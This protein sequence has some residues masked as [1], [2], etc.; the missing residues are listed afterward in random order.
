MPLQ[1]HCPSSAAASSSNAR[2]CHRSPHIR[3]RER[4]SVLCLCLIEPCARSSRKLSP[5]VACA[6][7]WLLLSYLCLCLRLSLHRCSWDLLL[8]LLLLVLVLLL[9]LRHAPSSCLS[10]ALCDPCCES[11]PSPPPPPPSPSPSPTHRTPRSVHSAA[12]R[13]SGAVRARTP[14]KPFYSRHL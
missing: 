2:Q 9:L 7:A 5:C 8:L 12:E 4:V 13:A 10:S 6:C 3:F 1:L 14:P 11:L